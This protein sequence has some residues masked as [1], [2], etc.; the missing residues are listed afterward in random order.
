VAGLSP[1]EGSV[2]THRGFHIKSSPRPHDPDP[3]HI[4]AILH[5]E[6]HGDVGWQIVCPNATR[7]PLY[8]SQCRAGRTAR[9]ATSVLSG[10]LV[11][12]RPIDSKSDAHEYRR[13]CPASRT[14]R[15]RT[16]FAV[17]RPTPL[18]VSSA[19]ISSGNPSV[20]FL[21]QVAAYSADDARLGPIEP[22]RKNQPLEC[23]QR[24]PDYRLRR[25]RPRE[26]PC[27]RRRSRCVL[28]P[29]D[30][31]C[32]KIKVPERIAMLHCDEAHDR[33]IPRR[34]LPPQHSQ[35]ATDPARIERAKRFS[36]LKTVAFSVPIARS[37]NLHL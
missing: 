35:R 3:R 19:S 12:T 13:R 8:S 28:G 32:T 6:H 29:A 11:R 24:Q 27:R 26:Q 16:R 22:H 23:L 10:V 2:E 33:R 15:S 18:S 34:R 20:K 1:A 17:L 31:G 9:S 25:M 5:R 30:S 4:A 14:P 36:F 21:D 7:I 37:R